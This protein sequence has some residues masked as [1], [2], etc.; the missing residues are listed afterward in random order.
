MSISPP[1][2][3]PLHSR[4]TP[5][6]TSACTRRE[7][8][9]S[10]AVR[11]DLQLFLKDSS[12]PCVYCAHTVAFLYV[13]NI[14]TTHYLTKYATHGLCNAMMLTWPFIPTKCFNLKYI[15]YACFQYTYTNISH[16]T[17][18]LLHLIFEKVKKV[19]KLYSNN[20]KKQ[21]KYILE[22]NQA[23]K[24]TKNNPSSVLQN[25]YNYLIRLPKIYELF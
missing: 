20:I 3:G 2:D 10:L 14:W 13:R 23:S 7:M 15:W 19:G 16:Q 5:T 1:R 6:L 8:I 17:I 25:L 18:K 22:N 12:M 21:A 24:Q 4:S 9:S 11:N